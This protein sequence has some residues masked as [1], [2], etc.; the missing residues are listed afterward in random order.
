[1]AN[2]FRLECWN[3]IT[4]SILHPDVIYFPN[5]LDGYNFWMVST[6]YPDNFREQNF[7]HRTN[8]PASGWINIKTDKSPIF[9]CNEV[10]PE[11][12]FMADPDWLYIPAYGKFFLVC[13]PR[14]GGTIHSSALS[15][16]NE[17]LTFH[18]S[19]DGITWTHYK[20]GTSSINGNTGP[21]IVSGN[22][23]DGRAWESSSG[24][25]H[26]QYPTMIFEN[27]TFYLW[28]G[29]T[30]GNLDDAEDNGYTNQVGRIGMATFTWNNNT[31]TI[32]NFTRYTG[33]YAGGA[34]LE[35]A[36]DATYW[37]GIGHID[38]TRATDGTY[39]MIGCRLKKSNNKEVIVR[40]TSTDKVTW[41]N[42]TL[43]IDANN[44]AGNSWDDDHLY[45]SCYIQDGFGNQ[46]LLNGSAQV[47]YSAWSSSNRADI[48][49]LT[50][51]SFT[52][53]YTY[54]STNTA[55]TILKQQ[56]KGITFT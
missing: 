39:V 45:R 2:P 6:P 28:Y 24:K 52:T 51:G 37:G 40:L 19:S 12:V 56:N 32:E 44:D 29:D 8:D 10:F 18:Y 50:Q 25:S 9:A 26:I 35:L 43:L 55:V 16:R 20:Q 21:I 11:W 14:T 41:G 42:Q 33:A 47:I 30:S 4:C 17:D 22:D 15:V 49:I 54:A 31:N 36:A 7:V 27:G 3:N 34:I 38:V 53:T 13:G 48:G 23:T 5:G 46:V 1:M